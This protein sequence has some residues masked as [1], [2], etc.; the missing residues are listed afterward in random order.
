MVA[1]NAQNNTITSTTYTNTT[2]KLNLSYN[3]SPTDEETWFALPKINS[4][5]SWNVVYF[6]FSVDVYSFLQNNSY[7]SSSSSNAQND[8]SVAEIVERSGAH[9]TQGQGILRGVHAAKVCCVL[10]AKADELFHSAALRLALPSLSSF[11]NELCK[12]SHT[13]V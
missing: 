13:Q 8:A 5:F 1:Q 4:E 6:F 3:A 12:A 10:S 2:E 11:L 9:N 7:S